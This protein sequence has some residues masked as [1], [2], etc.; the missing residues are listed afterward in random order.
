MAT[1]A[2]DG[3]AVMTI[4]GPPTTG[5]QLRPTLAGPIQPMVLAALTQLHTIHTSKLLRK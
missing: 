3:W 1:T 4:Q 5:E 2:T